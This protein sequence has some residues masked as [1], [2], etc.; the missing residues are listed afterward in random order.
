ME[1][2]IRGMPAV[3]VE[4]KEWDDNDTVD[5][6]WQ[7]LGSGEM[8]RGEMVKWLGAEN[9]PRSHTHLRLQGS[10]KRRRAGHWAGSDVMRNCGL[11]RPL[12]GSAAAVASALQ[13]R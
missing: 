1:M 11:D 13:F 12:Q 9:N 8:L 5:K 6:F 7:P 10:E 2:I 3:E 4:L